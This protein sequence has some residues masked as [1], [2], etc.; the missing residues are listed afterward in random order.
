MCGISGVWRS[1]RLGV[2]S[3]LSESLLAIKH[4]G[5][6]GSGFHAE[7]GVAVGMRRL[8]II[9]VEGG[10]QPIW[11]EAQDMCVV[12]NGEIYNYVELLQGLRAR[13]HS[14]ATRSDTESVIHLYEDDSEGFVRHLRGMFALAV[15][16]RRRGQLVLARD[17]FGKKPSITLQ[18]ARVV[19]CSPPSSRRLYP[20][21]EPRACRS[22]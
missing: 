19:S 20:L 12:L 4:R 3:A 18:L 8:S 5:P 13:G 9:D 14:L 17:R 22:R 15:F 11:N 16:D 21:C 6:D 1:E 2:E 7:G 10:N